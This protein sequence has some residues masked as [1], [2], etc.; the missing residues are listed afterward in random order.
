[1][2]FAACLLAGGETAFLRQA[3][4]RESRGSDRRN[5]EESRPLRRI[6]SALSRYDRQDFK[7]LRRD[8]VLLSQLFMPLILF[9]I[10]F[11]LGIQDRS[12]EV[13]AELYPCPCNDRR[14]SLMPDQYL[15]RPVCLESRFWILLVSPNGGATLLRAKFAMSVLIPPAS[16][17]ADL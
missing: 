15:S 6:F 3:S 1:V 17:Y 11:L 4:R 13:S 7:Y 10:P 9:F 14:D 8:S 12:R 2:L 16:P 5:A